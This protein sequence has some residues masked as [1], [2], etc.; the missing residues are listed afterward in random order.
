MS[1][2]EN[3]T[4]TTWTSSRIK[5]SNNYHSSDDQLKLQLKFPTYHGSASKIDVYATYQINDCFAV[6]ETNYTYI[7]SGAPMNYDVNVRS[8]VAVLGTDIQEF[9]S[10]KMILCED[11]LDATGGIT[12]LA[13]P[14]FIP[15]SYYE[16]ASPPHT[17]TT[18]LNF[19]GT[20]VDGV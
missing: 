8:P 14:K 7:G 15:Y 20:A 11:R 9:D 6:N 19:S 13:N 3:E 1:L 18:D 2:P 10:V 5:S 17:E 12:T 16:Y 4:I